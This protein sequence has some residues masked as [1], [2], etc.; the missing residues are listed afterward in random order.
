M[1][2]KYEVNSI[3]RGDC[4]HILQKFPKESADLIYL[5]PPF[6]SNKNYEIIW[7]NGHEIRAFE[8]RWKGGIMNYIDWLK[9]RIEPCYTVLKKTGT[10]FLHCDWRAS[11]HIRVHVL[12]EIFGYK[13][14]LNEIIWKFSVGGRSSE[15]FGRKHNTIFWYRKGKKWTFNKDAISVPRKTGYKSFGGRIVEEDGKKYQIKLAKSGKEYKYRLDAG[16]TPE[17]VW[18]IE[19]IQSQSKE[20][21]GYPTQKPESLLE[22]IIE[23][24]SNE[25]DVVLDPM[26]GCGTTIAVA[27]KLK[28]QFVGVDVSPTACKLM[29]K[30]IRKLGGPINI[31]YMPTNVKELKEL[32][33]FDFQN[34]VVEQYSGRSERKTG[35]FGIDGYT[36]ESTPIQ[37]KQSERVGRNVV[38]NFE[39]AIR[40]KKKKEGI[41]VAFSFTKGAY[42]EAK[43]AKIEG[44]LEIKLV[45]VKELLDDFN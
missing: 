23:A 17:D 39:T 33:H 44:G 6:F 8:D 31:Y 3:Y 2:K 21:L 15:Y 1:S 24:A 28:R 36:F 45:T 37:V 4:K 10:L 22:R 40:R 27:Y 43:R 16:K 26:C 35:D 25:G 7:G 5:D 29:G 12:D 20:R 14:F 30:R 9:S 34:W 32:N 41:V 13:N 38:D 42:E 19:S 11:H 18:E